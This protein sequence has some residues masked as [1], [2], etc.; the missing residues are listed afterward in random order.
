MIGF[1]NISS[2]LLI[3]RS[4]SSSDSER[5]TSS[6]SKRHKKNDRP[7]KVVVELL[8]N[9]SCY[10]LYLS[11]YPSLFPFQFLEQG[12]GPKQESSP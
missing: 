10:I 3:C 6:H 2:L 4:D 12:K 8:F 7:K 1:P 5:E 9:S 11:S